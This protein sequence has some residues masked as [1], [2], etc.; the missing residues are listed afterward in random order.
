MKEIENSSLV[1]SIKEII[2][3]AKRVAF[4][5]TN[6]ILLN[7][8][9]EIGR[10]IVE[11]EQGGKTK[12]GYGKAV[13]KN[14]SLHLTLEF[15]KGFDESNLRNIR[16]FYLAF[17]KRDAVRHELSW[18]HYRILSRVEDESLRYRYI[19]TAIEGGWD[20]RA[21][22]RNI[23]TQYL[24]RVLAPKKKE[25]HTA[26]SLLKDPYIFEFLGMP[27]DTGITEHKVEAALL[28]HLQQFLMEL[29]KG[30]AFVARQQH[31]VTDT[32]DFYIDL[33]FYNYYLKC[34]VLIDLKIDKLSHAD[35][36]QMDMY[37]R[38]YNDLKKGA[39]D[40]PTIGMILCTEK[41]ETIVKYSVLAENE[42]LFASKYRLYLPK[43]EEL[44]QLIERDRLNLELD[45]EA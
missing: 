45:K 21:L 15:G 39:D 44:V 24:D 42:K 35:I 8:Y 32:S 10:L 11:D 23:K 20:T 25:G 13:L 26:Q 38:M 4:K 6:S 17:Q 37:V 30:F 14:L 12:A 28:H 16:Q 40:Q 2:T 27:T 43:E 1:V 9:W 33:V 5:S 3:T 22:Q 29:G 41:D 31:I 19:E 34:F 36:G 18:T 7:M